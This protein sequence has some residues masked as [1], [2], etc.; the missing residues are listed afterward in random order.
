MIARRLLR[1]IALI[2]SIGA[3]CMVLMGSLVAETGSGTGCGKSW[4]FCQGQL[5]PDSI[6][7]AAF[8]EYTHRVI[9]GFDGLFIFVLAVFAWLV[10]RKD[11]RVKFFAFMS[12]LFVLVQGALGALTVMYEGSFAEN[13]LLALHFGF[14][15]ICFASV[16][17]LTIR[18]FQMRSLEMNKQQ[19]TLQTRPIARGIQY[20]IWGIT[21]YTYLVVYTGALV[22]HSNAI[23]GCGQQFPACTTAI[24]GLS[25]L[26]GIQLLHRYSAASIWLILLA[27]MLV[28]LFRQRDNRELVIASVT[29]FLL[30]TLQA[31]IGMMIIFSD[32]LLTVELL[33][34]TVIAVLFSALCYIC[35]QIGWPWRKQAVGQN[36]VAT[37]SEGLQL[38]HH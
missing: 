9:S 15:L 33:H 14:S 27:F 6:T 5:L 38:S 28:V 37:G 36:R 25:S 11:F 1:I 7:T 22:S 31:F 16:I 4:P 26:A 12:L 13:G 2:T 34:S 23:M 3:Y 29:A 35:M 24:P 32:G 19:G 17:L 10:Y 30:V 20:A 18:L 21:A 8:F